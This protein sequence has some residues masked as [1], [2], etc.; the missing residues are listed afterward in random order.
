MMG[1]PSRFDL[2]KKKM[3]DHHD[4]WR[5]LSSIPELIMH[6]QATTHMHTGFD[7]HLATSLAVTYTALRPTCLV[8]VWRAVIRERQ[9]I[10]CHFGLNPAQVGPN[11]AVR[12][13]DID[14]D[15]RIGC[16]ASHRRTSSTPLISMAKLTSTSMSPTGAAGMPEMRNSPIRLLLDRV[17]VAEARTRIKSSVWLSCG[18]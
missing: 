1:V 3:L 18:M 4:L 15:V 16:A 10:R 2:F 7:L 9:Q 6:T 14:G 13:V 17:A 5:R 12:V 11:A 8:V